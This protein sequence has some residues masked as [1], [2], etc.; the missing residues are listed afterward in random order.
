VVNISAK[1]AVD[2]RSG[3]EGDIL[4]TV[5]AASQAGLAGVTDNVGFNGDAVAEFEVGDVGSDRDN[6]TGRFV[7]E[8]VVSSD[9]HGANATSVPKVD[10]GAVVAVR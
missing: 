3:E 1:Q 6:L 5:V 4:A 9:D 8:D 2:G 7:T 10:V